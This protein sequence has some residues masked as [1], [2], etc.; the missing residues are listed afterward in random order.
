MSQSEWY[1]YT[2]VQ[3]GIGGGGGVQKGLKRQYTLPWMFILV[4]RTSNPKD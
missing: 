3:T 2:E 4:M 1:F